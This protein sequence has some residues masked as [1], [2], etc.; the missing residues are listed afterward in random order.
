MSKKNCLED[1]IIFNSESHC[2]HDLYDSSL[3]HVY[4]WYNDYTMCQ[5]GYLKSSAFK[6]KL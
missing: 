6:V 3:K 5:L 2:Q 4:L 1:L